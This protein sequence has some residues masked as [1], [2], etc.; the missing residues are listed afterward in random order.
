MS[1][2][3]IIKPPVSRS[4]KGGRVS[5]APG[6]EIGEHV[7][8]DKEELLIILEGTATLKKAGHTVMLKKGDAHFI[9]EGVTH[10]VINS[11]EDVLEYIYVVSLFK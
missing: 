11:S 10:N 6:E 2:D 9:P 1:S 7:T 3:S 5:L 8:D 4:L